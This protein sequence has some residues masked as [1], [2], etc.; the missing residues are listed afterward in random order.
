MYSRWS[1]YLYGPDQLGWYLVFSQVAVAL[2]VGVLVSS[3]DSH[4]KVPSWKISGTSS[5]TM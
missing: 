1:L 3:D 5:D 2:L 4:T